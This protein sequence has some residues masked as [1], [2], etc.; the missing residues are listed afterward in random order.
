MN[1]WLLLAGAIVAEVIGT[2]S[3]RATVDQSAWIALVVVAYLIAFTLL[4]LTLRTG[5]AVGL[6]YG[7]WGA[8]GVALVALLSTVL[9]GERL[10]VPAMIGIAVIVIG[11][12][13]VETGARPEVSSPEVES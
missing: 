2:L 1:R 13:V 6:V 8:V 4:G 10:S 5:M 9:F 11:V 12:F 7:I 3:L